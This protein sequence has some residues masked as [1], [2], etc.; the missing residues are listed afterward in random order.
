MTPL[1]AASRLPYFVPA[2]LV[3]S[4]AWLA[5]W[6]LVSNPGYFSHDELQWAAFA[7][8]GRSFPWLAVDAFQ[9]R[10]LTFNLWLALSRW[11]FDTPQAF[12]SVLVGWGSANAALLFVLTRR[13]GSA[14]WP[15]AAGALLFALGPYAAYVHGWVGTIGDLAWV[16]CGLLAMLLVHRNARWPLAAVVAAVATLVGLLAKE[17]ALALPALFVVAWLVDGRS[18]RW[19]AATAASGVV[20]IAYLAVR[21]DVLLHAPRTGDQYT[22]SAANV[23]LRWV[24]YQVYPAMSGTAEVFNTFIGGVTGS[25]MLSALLWLALGT[26]LWR[27]GWRC[28]VVWF[29]G[30]IA[31][32][33]PVLPMAASWN[34]YAYGFA[35][36]MAMAM[37]LAWRGAPR[38]GRAILVV[39]GL[40]VVAHGQSVTHQVREVGEVQARFSPTLTRALARCTPDAGLR[41]RPAPEA[42]AWIFARIT[43]N[44]PSYEGVSMGDRVALAGPGEPADMEIA[45]D[46]GLAWLPGGACSP[47]ASLRP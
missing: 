7:A 2:L 16:T 47:T 35:A 13:C 40:L 45:R 21:L 5:Q 22:V 18:R 12:H 23:P 27:A 44:I 15:A 41:L 25:V 39:Y 26:V 14:A 36:T 20:A 1:T 28:F 29:A 34:Q 11:L 10:P 42:D 6:P 37:A 8:E 46:G 32:L 9:Y 24:E 33:A 30:G 43:H 4:V 38:W 31:A 19:A 17:A 3:F